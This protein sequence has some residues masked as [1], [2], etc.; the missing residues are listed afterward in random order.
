MAQLRRI[1]LLSVAGLVGVGVVAGA[2]L[3]AA[4]KAADKKAESPAGGGGGGGGGG[5]A[6]KYTIEEVMEK[7]HKGKEKSMFSRVVA[8]KGSDED[9]KHLVEYYEAMLA[10][11][12]P[13]G[14]PA[15]WAKRNEAILAAAKK[16]QSGDDQ[17][18][19][20][21]LKTAAN[22]KQCHDVHKES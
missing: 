3:P 6:P 9:K 4:E 19:L 14:E 7:A 10:N 20:A 12:P 15:D 8:G 18:N 21:A 5:G 16:V 22:C 13:K 11:K 2:L 1:G 17:K